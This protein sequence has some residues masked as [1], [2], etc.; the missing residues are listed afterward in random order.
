MNFCI[1]IWIQW[2]QLET[3]FLVV[4]V[5]IF[6]SLVNL[7][8]CWMNQT[9][10]CCQNKQFEDLL[11]IFVAVFFVCFIFIFKYTYINIYL[12]VQQIS[13]A[14]YQTC[15]VTFLGSISVI[16]FHKFHWILV[17]KFRLLAKNFVWIQTE[18]CRT[19]K[20]IYKFLFLFV[21]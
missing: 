7:L 4:Y 10:D 16:I 20:Y 1:Y 3:I 2:P 12:R 6:I 13:A 14:C 15:V 21:I 11:I 19:L 5:P 17:L 8:I 9:A 18:F